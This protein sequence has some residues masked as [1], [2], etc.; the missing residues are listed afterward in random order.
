MGSPLR[1]SRPGQPSSE[2]LPPLWDTPSVEPRVSHKGLAHSPHLGSGGGHPRAIPPHVPL[3]IQEACTESR[4][5]ESL[6]LPPGKTGQPPLSSSQGGRGQ[7]HKVTSSRPENLK[8]NEDLSELPAPRQAPL[9]RATH[10][11]GHCTASCPP[12]PPSSRQGTQAVRPLLSKPRPGRQLQLTPAP[13]RP[14]N[15]P[16]HHRGLRARPADTGAKP[17]LLKPSL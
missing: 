8:A 15:P 4:P 12:R 5:G 2:R 11:R 10:T 1:P 7:G 13:I 14:R 6:P 9:T 17:A 16:L 3:F